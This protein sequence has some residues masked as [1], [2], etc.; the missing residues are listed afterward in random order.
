MQ[1]TLKQY[2]VDRE[3][4][5]EQSSGQQPEKPDSINH[6]SSSAAITTSRDPQPAHFNPPGSQQRQRPANEHNASNPHAPPHPQESAR[7]AS[8][9]APSTPAHATSVGTQTDGQQSQRWSCSNCLHRNDPARNP[10]LCEACNAAKVSRGRS[11]IASPAGSGQQSH[12]W[13]CSNGSHRN[14]PATNPEKCAGCGTRQAVEDVTS[15]SWI[16]L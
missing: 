16:M 8:N 6:R 9:A 15:G 14:D 5:Q 12:R 7:Y 10:E 13:S 1:Q 3:V 4:N 2:A 11:H